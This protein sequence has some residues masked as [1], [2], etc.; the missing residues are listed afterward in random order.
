MSE[1]VCV[2]GYKREN[3]TGECVFDSSGAAP[4]WYTQF[5]NQLPLLLSLTVGVGFAALAFAMVLALILS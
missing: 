4:T 2:E 3:A 5:G 1:C